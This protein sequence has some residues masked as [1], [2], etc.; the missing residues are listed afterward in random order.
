MRQIVL[1]TE[2]TGLET[3]DG[4]RIIEIGCVEVLDRVITGN[5]YHVY[6]QP[7][8]EIDA[9]AI[10]VHGISNEF[11]ADKPRFNDIMQEFLDFVDGA[12]LVIHNAAFDIGFI[13]AE[14]QWAGYNK[15]IE[16]HCSVLDTLALAREMYPGQRAS[17]D[18]LCKRLDINNAHR[19]LHGALLDSEILAEVY[20][21]MTG[22]QTSLLLEEEE[23]D[24]LDEAEQSAVQTRRAGLRVVA[25][26]GAEL[27]AHEQWLDKL[28]KESSQGCLW[29]NHRSPG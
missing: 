3:S 23:S 25:A 28:E 8:R 5:N 15:S 20:L 18:A 1:D 29:R 16:A 17:L 6:L 14:L 4:H 11:L 9:G 26:S 10:E 13:N 7:D 12:Q 22:G 24:D 19:T 2:T 21:M 27:E